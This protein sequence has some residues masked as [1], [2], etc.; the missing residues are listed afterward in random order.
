VISGAGERLVIDASVAVKWV[1]SETDS[2]K[3][4]LLLDQALVAPDLLFAECAN[5]LWKKVRRGEMTNEEAEIAAQTLEQ[6]DLTVVSARAYI[7]RAAA[8]AIELDHPAYDGLYL[9]V[10]EA[11]GLRLVTADDR[12]VRKVRQ[13]GS[14]FQPLVLPLSEIKP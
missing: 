1:V 2:D 14:R 11:L 13:G 6:A 8:L 10:A 5:I 7:A 9:A 12:L 3:A 4:Q